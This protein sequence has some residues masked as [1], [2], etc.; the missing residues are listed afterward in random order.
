MATSVP[1]FRLNNGTTMPA[2][3]IG[4]W[5]GTVGGADD[6]REM[7]E[8]ALKIGYRHID[9]AWAYKNEVDVGKAIRN[10]G[11]P[12]DQ[13]YLVT[14]LVDLHHG[15]VQEAFNISLKQLGVDY[16]DLYLMH[17][18]QAKDPKTDRT[19]Q[20]SESPTFVETWKAMEKL[21]DTGK[22]KSIGV[23][24]FSPKNLDI[25][26][27]HAKVVPVTNQ[28]EMHPLL[29]QLELLEYCRTKGIVITAYTPVARGSPD[30]FEHASL[31]KISARLKCE[32]VQ[33]IMGWFIKKGVVAIP[34]SA[35]RTRLLQNLT[36]VNISE[37]DEAEIDAI[38]KAP[39]MHRSVLDYHV[40]GKVFGW[41]HEQL[42]WPF[43][44]DGVVV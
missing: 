30:L 9:T 42:G 5:M 36:H 44:K 23:S 16:I 22:V 35:N 39:G 28:V 2:I 12:R 38:H 31:K 7:V 15:M 6:V 26:L 33:V 25:L 29:P 3:G 8:Y 37:E 17:W 21:L 32:P 20:P 40:D 19:L 13:I 24:N 10:S 43:N 1:S 11:I 14:K 34:K 41:T 27:P 4:C 18:P